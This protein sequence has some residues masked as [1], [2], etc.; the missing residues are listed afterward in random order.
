MGRAQRRRD[1]GQSSLSS[2]AVSALKLERPEVRVQLICNEL[3]AISLQA[4][5]RSEVRVQ[6]I[7]HQLFAISLLAL[8][9]LEDQRLLLLFVEMMISSS[10][11]SRC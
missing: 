9:G 2:K 3:F 8:E 5:E 1:S 10:R 7:C 11:R 6:H 4:R